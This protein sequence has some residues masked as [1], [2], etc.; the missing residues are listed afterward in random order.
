MLTDADRALQLRNPT[1]DELIQHLRYL[2]HWVKKPVTWAD[3][4]MNRTAS[5]YD[6]VR[7]ALRTL[8]HLYR[9]ERIAPLELMDWDTPPFYLLH[10]LPSGSV[11]LV[12]TEGYRYVRYAFEVHPL[13][14]REWYDERLAAQRVPVP[15]LRHLQYLL[16]RFVPHWGPRRVFEFPDGL[17]VHFEDDDVLPTP[18]EK[19]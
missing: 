16:Q 15:G 5:G 10:L 1:P 18:T 9:D 4:T 12:N 3:V 19:E 13:D 6:T 11:V 2:P 17:R 8:P 7:Y 14:V